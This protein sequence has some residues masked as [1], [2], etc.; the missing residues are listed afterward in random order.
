MKIFT[1]YYAM[2]HKIREE[3]PHALIIA[4][5][6]HIDERIQNSVDVWTKKLAPTKKIYFDYKEDSDWKKYVENYKTERL[7]LF[8]FLEYFEYLESLTED[9]LTDVFLLCYEKADDGSGK[10]EFCHRHIIAEA[11]EQEF[12]TTVHEFKHSHYDRIDY[13]MNSR[14]STDC[15]F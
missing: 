13:R 14:I 3:F 4:T 1:S 2:I 5:S 7:S 12:N 8:D 10:G 9:G 6:G 11:I 15:L